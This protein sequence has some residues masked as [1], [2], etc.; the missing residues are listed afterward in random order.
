M[1]RE[2]KWLR[3]EIILP[4]FDKKQKL[5]NLVFLGAGEKKPFFQITVKTKR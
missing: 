3:R 4:P 5:P 2:S 1:E